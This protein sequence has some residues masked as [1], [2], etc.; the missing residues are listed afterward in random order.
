MPSPDRALT[1]ACIDHPRR[2]R[3]ARAGTATWSRA[4]L[5]GLLLCVLHPTYAERM[6]QWVDPQTG[7][8]QLGGQPPPWFRRA[9]PGPRVRVYEHGKVID[10]TALAPP[11]VA[12]GP[13]PATALAVPGAPATIEATPASSAGGAAN[14]VQE[15]KALLE[16]WDRAQSARAAQTRPVPPTDSTISPPPPN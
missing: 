15:F 5:G 13:A 2:V 11:P 1:T 4:I 3:P 12:S 7:T 8:V 6:Y 16:V 9:E 10:D 14:Q